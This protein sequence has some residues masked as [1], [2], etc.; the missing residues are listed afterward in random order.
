MSLSMFLGRVV[1][2]G[3]G[4]VAGR[5]RH[6]AVGPDDHAAQSDAGPVRLQSIAVQ[7]PVSRLTAEG[8]VVAY[9]G[10]G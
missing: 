1:L 6:V 10:A 8:R 4:L 7:E 9:P 2:P 3:A 5:R